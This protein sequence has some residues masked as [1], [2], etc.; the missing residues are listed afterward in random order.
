[1]CHP[2]MPA[3][4]ALASQTAILSPA[5]GAGDFPYCCLI[6]LNCCVTC[7]GDIQH[8]R[9]PNPSHHSGFPRLWHQLSLLYNA[10]PPT[11]GK[12]QKRAV[13]QPFVWLECVSNSE[14]G[15][16]GSCTTGTTLTVMIT[17]WVQSTSRADLCVRA[18]LLPKAC[19]SHHV[20]IWGSILHFV[21]KFLVLSISY[22]II[23][24][25]SVDERR[26]AHL[27]LCS[28]ELHFTTRYLRRAEEDI[29]AR[30]YPTHQRLRQQLATA[31]HN[32]AKT[33]LIWSSLAFS[34]WEVSDGFCS[35]FESSSPWRDTS[36]RGTAASSPLVPAPPGIRQRC[37]ESLC[38][39]TEDSW[40]ASAA[41]WIDAAGLVLVV[42]TKSC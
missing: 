36:G 38:L 34:L 39:E 2:F 17:Q 19:D 24:I 4:N 33:W 28:S 31:A 22:H 41:S 25:H 40:L 42:C 16:S 35:A 21:S 14:T 23:H 11:C 37:I 27:S 7:Q 6:V 1:M 8:H 12:S 20:R 9:T 13:C 26:S 30:S 10:V 15:Y 32:W 3:A 18:T 5:Q 29:E